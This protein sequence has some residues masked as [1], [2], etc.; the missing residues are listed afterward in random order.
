MKGK[1]YVRE[2]H[3]DCVTL[4]EAPSLHIQHYLYTNT[5][6]SQNCGWTDTT[7]PFTAL[8][9][10]T[11]RKYFVSLFRTGR[12]EQPL[13]NAA[14][15]KFIAVPRKQARCMGTLIKCV[16]GSTSSCFTGI[17]REREK[18]ASTSIPRQHLWIYVDPR[19]DGIKVAPHTCMYNARS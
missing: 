8:K 1:V 5:H 10:Q 12:R 7:C 11:N 14:A 18:Q 15:D 4:P 19:A 16:A 2:R 9:T 3:T 13:L 6:P 17:K